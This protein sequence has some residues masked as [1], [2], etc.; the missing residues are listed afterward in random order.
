MKFRRFDREH[1]ANESALAEKFRSAMPKDDPLTASKPSAGVPGQAAESGSSRIANALESGPNPGEAT[2]YRTAEDGTAMS[3]PLE[4][5]L[6]DEVSYRRLSAS[7]RGSFTS[8]N[9]EEAAQLGPSRRRRPGGSPPRPRTEA[10]DGTSTVEP[11]NQQATGMR[12]LKP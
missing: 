9:A 6:C 10:P 3:R 7:W 8:G 11:P 12:R 4:Y 1:A 2:V 5:A